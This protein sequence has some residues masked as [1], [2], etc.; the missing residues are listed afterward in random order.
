MTIPRTKKKKTN[1]LTVKQYDDM[2]FYLAKQ[3]FPNFIAMTLMGVIDELEFGKMKNFHLTQGEKQRLVRAIAGR[4]DH[5]CELSRNG[6][7]DPFETRKSFEKSIGY[8][9]SNLYI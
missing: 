8:D 5:Y 7:I 2:R 6:D 4:I 9:F 3:I 1:G